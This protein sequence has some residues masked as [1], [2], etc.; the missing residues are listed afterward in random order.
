MKQAPYRGKYWTKISLTILERDDFICQHCGY[1]G[2]RETLDC[3]HVIPC[4][5]F[6]NT[7]DANA[8]HNLIALCRPC[9][10]KADNEYWAMHPEFFSTARLPY[11]TVPPRPCEICGEIMDKPSPNRKVCD[12]CSTFKCDVCGK[13]FISRKR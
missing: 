3:H 8:R 1:I 10:S 5:L 9:H 7:R 12:K 11:P 6:K 13:V 2:T 4:R